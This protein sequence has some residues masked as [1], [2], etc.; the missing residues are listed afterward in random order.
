MKLGR[1]G[2]LGGLLIAMLAAGPASAATLVSKTVSVGSAVDRSCTARALDSGGGYSRQTV[3]MPASGAIDATLEATSGDWD[4]AVFAAD[5]K[6][7]V[8]ARPRAAH[9]SWQWAS[10]W[11]AAS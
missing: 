11:R 3:T 1:L 5:G 9:P 10:P 6:R 4:V 8:A 7:V 2:C